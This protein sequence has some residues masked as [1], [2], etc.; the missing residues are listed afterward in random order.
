VIHSRA[1]GN[2]ECITIKE[3][4]NIF[5]LVTDITGFSQSN[6]FGNLKWIL[7]DEAQFLTS[8]QVEELGAI[9]DTK[10]INVICY[11]LRTDF[12]SRLFDGSK[13][14]FELA[15]TIEEIKSSCSCGSKTIMNARINYDGN[16]IDEGDQIV[17]GGEDKYI[18]LCRACYFSKLGKEN[19]K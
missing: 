10:N 6:G 18:A 14:L 9:A 8:E 17:V 4:T 5:N 13:R 15:D 19:Y 11:G 7:V 2:R 3:D 12:Q 16:I 1:L